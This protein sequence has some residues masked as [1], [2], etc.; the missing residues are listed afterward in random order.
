MP[1]VGD[2]HP[3]GGY[4][5]V[6]PT[7][8]VL[9]AIRAH[10]E[11]VRDDAHR[12][13]HRERV[14]EVDATLERP[15]VDQVVGDLANARLERQDAARRECPSHRLAVAR[16]RR[17]IRSQHGVD[18][19]VTLG[20][21]LAQL[22]RQLP[23]TQPC[24][25]VGEAGREQERLGQHPI[26]RVEARDEE[27]ARRRV[28]VDGRLAPERGVVGEGVLLD[29]PLHRVVPGEID[30]RFVR[31]AHWQPRITGPDSPP[32]PAILESPPRR[33][34]AVRAC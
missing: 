12:E 13:R 32:A 14:D 31:C 16:L 1:L 5:V 30:L 9:H 20:G 19:G 34:Q 23:G 29:R 3:K 17:W 21:D 10:V 11:C 24:G 27:D 8:D 26:H 7:L 22:G 15:G 2:L 4:R 6:G 28:P 33:G 25:Q 18:R